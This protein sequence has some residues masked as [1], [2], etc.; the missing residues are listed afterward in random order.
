MKPS[1]SP[2]VKLAFVCGGYILVATLY[3]FELSRDL[4]AAVTRGLSG[5]FRPHGA[6]D[7]LRNIVLFVPLGA[8]LLFGRAGE[9][10]LPQA[11]GRV[12][13]LGASFSVAIEFAQLLFPRDS[14]VF[15]VLA[16]TAGAILGA[17]AAYPVR[18]RLPELVGRLWPKVGLVVVLGLVGWGA[19]PLFLSFVQHRAPFLFW[20]SAFHLQLGNE[21]TGD[22]PWL[23]RIHLVALYD[24]A[25]SPEEIARNFRLGPDPP[26][27]D[28]RA[29]LGLVALYEFEEGEGDVIH[30]VSGSEPPLDLVLSPESRFRWL[31]DPPAIELVGPSM[32]RSA[33]A[34]RALT[35]ALRSAHEVT[36]E[37]W[38][39]PRDT[40]QGGPARIVSHSRDTNRRNFTLGQEGTDVVLRLRTP[41]TGSGGSRVV[42]VAPWT[43]RS[44]SRTHVVATYGQGVE[45]LYIDAVQRS[46][47]LELASEGIVGLGTPRSALARVAY[48]F[49][50][51]FP[52][53]FALAAYALPRSPASR[54]ARRLAFAVGAGLFA[55]AETVQILV[56]ERGPDLP[57]LFVAVAVLGVAATAADDETTRT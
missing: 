18:K 30:D 28:A 3:P 51:F 1:T 20:S 57:L 12:A 45:R 14:S 40:L 33:T 55:A 15:D 36:V 50:Y 17:F 21:G 27:R 6:S 47:P 44:P 2:S 31:E 5:F 37:V 13:L 4:P 26:R 38:M 56:L 42:H 54:A 16:N 48:T 25:L 34:A 53:T 11:L 9:R 41:V 43:R 32:A 19:V 52:V 35:R 49:V 7:F 22:R 29:S 8:L 46:P 39:T 10:A 23:G 24:R